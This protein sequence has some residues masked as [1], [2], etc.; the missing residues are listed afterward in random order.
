M[1]ST[2]AFAAK[3]RAHAATAAG[4]RSS[5][6]PAVQREKKSASP[7]IGRPV[8]EGIEPAAGVADE[9]ADETKQPTGV[10]CRGRLL[11]ATE[12]A[13]MI[14]PNLRDE[15]LAAKER[16]VRETVPHKLELAPKIRRWYESDIHAWLED[17][18]EGSNA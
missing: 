8:P 5:S 1:P 18:R 10:P 3:L 15:E 17:L 14:F 4:S 12:I 7:T 13:I 6:A 11:S 16:W 9:P 2:T